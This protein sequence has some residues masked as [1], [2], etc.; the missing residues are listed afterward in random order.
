MKRIRMAMTRPFS[1]GLLATAALA[2]AA[3]AGCQEGS[4]NPIGL[5]PNALERGL[6]AHYTF[7]EG[8]GTT[9]GDSSG[10]N[11]G[12]VNMGGTWIT[13]G[14][15][16]GAMRFDGFST[17]MVTNFPFV[18]EMMGF[19]VSYWIRTPSF[20]AGPEAGILG[21]ILSTEIYHVGGW[22]LNLDETSSPGVRTSYWD[23]DAGTYTNT[24]CACLTPG[25]WT[26]VAS[27]FDPVAG[28]LSLYVDGTLRGSV[29]AQQPIAPGTTQLLMGHWFGPLR[30]LLGDLDDVAIYNRPLSAAEVVALKQQSP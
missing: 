4:L 23:T 15:F 2:S 10:Q 29:T 8:T 1:G 27:V 6:I 22:E 20:D 12:G 11:L 30:F 13:D 19:S 3:A 16:L 7:D 5:A 21:T 24:A 9:V 25:V 17:V 14:R 26:H 28:T 18:N